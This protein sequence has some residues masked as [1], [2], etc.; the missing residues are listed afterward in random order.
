MLPTDPADKTGIAQ[1]ADPAV[2]EAELLR[3]TERGR[4]QALVAG[5]VDRAHELHADDFQLITPNGE[6]LSK[7]QYLGGIAAGTLDYRLWEPDAT[8]TVRLYDQTALIGR[9]PLSWTPKHWA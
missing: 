5:N 4:L 7:E 3:A 1:P 6:A 2:V 9:A 8:M